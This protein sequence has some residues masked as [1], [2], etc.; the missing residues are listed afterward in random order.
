MTMQSILERT[1]PID[2]PEASGEAYADQQSTYAVLE[3]VLR[4][5]QKAGKSGF[6]TSQSV[7]LIQERIGTLEQMFRDQVQARQRDL[8]TE[9]AKLGEQSEENKRLLQA[10]VEVADLSA[11]AL[12]AARR[13]SSPEVIREVEILFREVMRTLHRAGIETTAE[14]G[15]LQDPEYHE[16]V[17]AVDVEGRRRGEIIEIVRQGY[18]YRG[19]VLRIA[20]VVIAN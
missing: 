14:A 20:K 15:Q 16:V 7:E 10:S 18:R 17:D 3:E 11:A 6:K 8:E 9:R 1:R 5:T 13:H 2:M 4:I 19:A 12:N